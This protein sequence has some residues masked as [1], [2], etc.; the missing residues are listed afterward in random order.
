MVMAPPPPASSEP[1]AKAAAADVG[2]GGEF[3]S[4]SARIETICVQD[5][6]TVFETRGGDAVFPISS[7]PA[8]LPPAL[9]AAISPP[10]P[11][12]APAADA[13]KSLSSENEKLRYQAS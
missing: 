13:T 4:D 2:G 12:A 1:A 5:I 10:P 9:E 7:A 8:N 6:I 11:P 3:T